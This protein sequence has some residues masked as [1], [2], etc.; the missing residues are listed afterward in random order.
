MDAFE[1]RSARQGH[2]QGD[3]LIHLLAV[4]VRGHTRRQQRLHLGGQEEDAVVDRVEQRLDAEPI[5]S[6]EHALVVIV[7]EDEGEVSAEAIQAIG[8]ALLIEM[9]EDLGVGRRPEDMAPAPELVADRLVAVEF[10]VHGEMKGAV[11]ARQRLLPGREV[12]DGEPRVG[13][14]DPAIVGD[15]GSRSVGPAMAKGVRAGT[16]G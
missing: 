10:A 7:P 11:V 16:K 9:K 13:E 4:P 12:D 1:Q 6:G 3:E 5:A 8:A 14:A 2:A 15:P